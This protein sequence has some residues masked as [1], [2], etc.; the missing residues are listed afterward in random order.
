MA[1]SVYKR[2]AE[3]QAHFVRHE[4]TQRLSLQIL[5]YFGR[6]L[7]YGAK[8]DL[9]PKPHLRDGLRVP[10]LPRRRHVMVHSPCGSVRCLRCFRVR[11]ECPND[12]ECIAVHDRVH[13]VMIAGA[14]LYCARCGGYSFSRTVKLHQACRGKPSGPVA[15]SRLK[16]MEAGRHPVSGVFLG[17]P[18]AMG[19]PADSMHVLL[20][21]GGPHD[22]APGVGELV[23]PPGRA[24]ARS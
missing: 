4:R 6:L 15:A 5:L 1:K 3:I 21:D 24:G 23:A 13:F 17:V 22:E 16:K 7:Q 12:V 8:R 2:F 20:G 18:R 14:C 10:L 9:L 11:S 19:N